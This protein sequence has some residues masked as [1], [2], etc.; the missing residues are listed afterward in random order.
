[1]GKIVRRLLE[2][3]LPRGKSAFLWGPRKVGKSYWIAHHLAGAAVIDLLKTDLFSEYAA[4]PSL[5]RERYQ[6]H[7][8][9][10]VI[11]EVQ[12]VPAILDRVS[13]RLTV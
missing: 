5:L 8:G 10:V 2:I 3:K 9:L 4:R 6:D 12:K 7:R 11:D 1:M 13:P